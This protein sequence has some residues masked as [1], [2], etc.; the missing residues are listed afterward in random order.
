M[1]ADPCFLQIKPFSFHD[2]S[3]FYPDAT[4]EEK[5]LWFGFFGGIPAY[6]EKASS[7]PSPLKAIDNMT[8]DENGVL[9]QEPEFLVR[10]ELREPGAYFS[11]PHSL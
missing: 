6:A 5:A 3:L 7:F 2:I 9:Y 1:V 8:L 4:F 11:I 10:E